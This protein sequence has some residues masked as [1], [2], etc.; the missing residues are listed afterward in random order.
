MLQTNTKLAKAIAHLPSW[1][2]FTFQ[3]GACQ[4]VVH[5]DRRPQ[6]IQLTNPT[7]HASFSGGKGRAKKGFLSDPLCITAR[8]K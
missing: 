2:Q 1:E 6:Q 3:L 4:S 5:G 7:V 8:Q